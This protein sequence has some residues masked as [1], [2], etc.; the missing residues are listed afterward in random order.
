MREVG[1]PTSQLERLSQRHTEAKG[2]TMKVVRQYSVK[3][4][5]IGVDRFGE[6]FGDTYGK[7]VSDPNAIGQA[8]SEC[9]ASALSDDLKVHSVIVEPFAAFIA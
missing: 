8:V 7:E 9:I 6:P 3:V 4:H 1:Q 5:G 2:N